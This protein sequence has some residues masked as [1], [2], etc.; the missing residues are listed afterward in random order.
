MGT[1]LVAVYRVSFHSSG[2]KPVAFRD[3]ISLFLHGL[4]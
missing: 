4:L 3:S 2:Y 1:R